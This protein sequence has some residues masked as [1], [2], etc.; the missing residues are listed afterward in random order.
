V[1]LVTGKPLLLVCARG[2]AYALGTPA[3]KMDFQAPYLENIFRFI[4]F[5]DIRRLIVEPTL[6]AD[7]AK[8]EG[9]RAAALERARE[10]AGSF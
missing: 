2:G 9:T 4:G 1:G 10:L 5:T 6:G 8:V 3:E 7:P